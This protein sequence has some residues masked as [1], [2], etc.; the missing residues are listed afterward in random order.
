MTPAVAGSTGL[1]TLW[2]SYRREPSPDLRERLAQ[3]YL[4]LVHH[5]AWRIRQRI[6]TL[7]PAELVSAGSLGLLRAID[8]FDTARGLAFSTYAVKCIHGAMLDDLRQRDSVPRGV[9]SRA[10]RIEAARAELAARL[11]RAPT[12]AE[13]ASKLGVPLERYWRWRDEIG[14]VSGEGPR[15]G[16][17]PAADRQVESQPGM[18][19]LPG[20][21]GELL[22][23]EERRQVRCALARLPARMQQ[24]LALLYFEELTARQVAGILGVTESR[25]S[26]L[27]KQ[28]LEQMRIALT[29]AGAAR[30]G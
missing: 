5:A 28:A 10:R 17:A 29:A 1:A 11:G 30:G 26:Q 24:I 19:P 25:V 18:T 6:P 22:A 14:P 23:L 16:L 21:E 8:R 27:R 3:H 20:A 12:A 2:E 9:R 4:G 15:T 7:D 13:L